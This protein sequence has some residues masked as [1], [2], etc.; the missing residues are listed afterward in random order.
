MADKVNTQ[1][2]QEGTEQNDNGTAQEPEK[3]YTEKAVAKLLK[4]LGNRR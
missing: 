1:G 3:K 2:K 4:E